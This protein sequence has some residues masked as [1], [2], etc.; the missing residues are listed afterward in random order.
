M[1]SLHFGRS[2]PEVFGF[3]LDEPQDHV[4]VALAGP[5]QMRR[6]PQGR[7]KV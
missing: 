7:E 3:E 5:A 4:A 6:R 1:K 2:P